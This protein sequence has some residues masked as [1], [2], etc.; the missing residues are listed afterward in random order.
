MAE[1]SSKPF[2]TDAMLESCQGFSVRTV[3]NLVLFSKKPV[4]KLSGSLSGLLSYVTQIVRV[5]RSDISPLKICSKSVLELFLASDGVF[6]EA[7]KPVPSWP[8]EFEG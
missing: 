7:L 2:V 5:R 1:V 3:D 4:P 8:F 6:E